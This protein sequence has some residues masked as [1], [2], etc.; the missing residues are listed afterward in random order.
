MTLKK[1]IFIAI[2][3]FFVAC[4][5]KQRVNVEI[6]DIV[7]SALYDKVVSMDYANISLSQVDSLIDVYASVGDDRREAVGRLIKGAKLYSINDDFGAIDE[8]K[9]AEQNI[10]NRSV[11]INKTIDL[12]QR[13]IGIIHAYH[14]V[15]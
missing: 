2:V 15:V 4:G 5:N 9:I 7:L 14:L 12:R 6:A 10:A 3:L 13:N 8:L 1:S 11:N